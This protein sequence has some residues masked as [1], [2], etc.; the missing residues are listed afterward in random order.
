MKQ[1]KWLKCDLN[2][3]HKNAYSPIKDTGIQAPTIRNRLR[4]EPLFS[5]RTD[6]PSS[7]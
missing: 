6:P 4:R 1:S 7:Y 5:L 3:D 2:P